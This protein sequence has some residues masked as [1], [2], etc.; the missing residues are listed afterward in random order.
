ML[1]L[2]SMWFANQ[3][4]GKKK[5]EG[6]DVH[7]QLSCLEP[8]PLDKLRTWQLFQHMLQLQDVKQESAEILCQN[9]KK[10]S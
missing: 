5:N 3:A 6:K 7:V 10:N 8:Y 2:L 4:I 9:P 1:Y